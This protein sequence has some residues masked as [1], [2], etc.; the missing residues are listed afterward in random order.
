[1]A[2]SITLRD[3]DNDDDYG[4]GNDGEAAPGISLGQMVEN[5]WRPTEDEVR[6]IAEELLEILGYLHELRPP[7]V[8]RDIKP[9]VG[10]FVCMVW[11]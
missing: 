7:I 9:E 6:R 11:V 8:H 2:S 4:N 5:G 1:M 3:D 10:V